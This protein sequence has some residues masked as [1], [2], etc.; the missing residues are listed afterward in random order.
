MD[1]NFIYATIIFIITVLCIYC[2]ITVSIIGEKI[3]NYCLFQ[4]DKCDKYQNEPDKYDLFYD[5]IWI[6]KSS[7]KDDICAW[8]IRKNPNV[9]SEKLLIFCHGN[10]GNL[11]YTIGFITKILPYIQ[12]DILVFDYS[13]YG[14]SPGFPSE[15][16]M[17]DDLESCVGYLLRQWSSR[18]IYLYGHSLGAAVVLKIMSRYE[19]AVRLGGAIIEGSFYSLNH[20]SKEKSILFNFWSHHNQF[21]NFIRIQMITTPILLVHVL[22]DEIIPSSHSEKLF[23]LVSNRNNVKGLIYIYGSHND[24]HY[25]DEF[26]QKLDQFII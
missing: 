3:E 16:E 5:T 26:Y 2:I 21:K 19:G 8:L 6:P 11:D 23:Q 18:N 22:D 13:G 15:S 24:P 14:L 12:A 9:L 17:Y 20:L 7:K 1:Y 10:G 25:T 4:P